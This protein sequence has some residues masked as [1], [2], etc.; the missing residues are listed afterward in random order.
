MSRPDLTL[1]LQEEDPRLVATLAAVHAR[2][3]LARPEIILCTD[4][5]GEGAKLS[6]LLFRHRPDSL[7]MAHRRLTIDHLAEALARH[8]PSRLFVYGEG[9][10]GRRGDEDEID[11]SVAVLGY[12]LSFG[13]EP[14]VLRGYSLVPRDT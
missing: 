14:T 3:G 12:Q 4:P 5:V 2:N 13:S 6:E 7:L 8:R 11:R 9:L 1:G 10:L